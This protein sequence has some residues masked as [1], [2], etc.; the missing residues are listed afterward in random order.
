MVV[1]LCQC[2][3]NTPEYCTLTTQSHF[4]HPIC[5][6]RMSYTSWILSLIP[7]NIKKSVFKPTVSE[8]EIETK[9]LF[10]R[11]GFYICRR[12]WLLFK[13]IHSTCLGNKPKPKCLQFP[14]W[15]CIGITHTKAWLALAVVGTL[16]TPLLQ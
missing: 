10:K 15:D 3:A 16:S 8:R 9:S 4:S 7:Q 1:P 11:G 12:Q 6:L 5:C 13:V 14:R 2:V